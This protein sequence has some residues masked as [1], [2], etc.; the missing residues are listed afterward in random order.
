ME[1]FAQQGNVYRNES[2]HGADG[3]NIGLPDIVVSGGE[4]VT[5]PST[6]RD[7]TSPGQHRY[8]DPESP[9]PKYRGHSPEA[10]LSSDGPRSTLQ[11][12]RRVSDVSMLSTADMGG[13]RSS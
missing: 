7:I 9:S 2:L 1:K 8:M 5:P 6:T 12:S 10:S 13:M 3:C 11:R 4:P